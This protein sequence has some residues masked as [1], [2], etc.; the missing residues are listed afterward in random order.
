MYNFKIKSIVHDYGVQFI[1]DTQG[2]LLKE[3]KEGDVIIIDNKIKE[4]YK[5]LLQPVLDLY[6]HIGIDA[7]EKVKSYQG[8]MPIIE[9]LIDNGFR[10][11]HR[12]VA[13][14]GGITQD[15]TAFIASIMFKI[16]LSL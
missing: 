16:N 10:K 6:W 8:V 5:D 7:S 15:A 12:L 1:D 14:G 9:N 3:L 2:V 13:I 11:N 4:L